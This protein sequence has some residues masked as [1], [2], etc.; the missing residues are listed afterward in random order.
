MARMGQSGVGD[1]LLASART[2]G[3][4]RVATRISK[5]EIEE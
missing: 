5:Q 3:S 4:S 1:A 2:R